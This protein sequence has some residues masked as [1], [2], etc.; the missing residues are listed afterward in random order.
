MNQAREPLLRQVL[1]HTH[2]NYGQA[3]ELLGFNRVTL[4]LWTDDHSLSINEY[5]H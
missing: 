2:G 3:G 1:A 4:K 5:R